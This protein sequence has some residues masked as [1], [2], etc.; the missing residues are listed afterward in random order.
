MKNNG[1]QSLVEMLVAVTVVVIVVLGLVLA[2]TVSLRNAR[3]SKDQAL[4]S[5]YAQEWIEEARVLKET[6]PNVF[7]A[8]TSLCNRSPTA[9]G[10]IFTRS[11]VCTL[12]TVPGDSTKKIMRVVVSVQWTDA[13]GTHK[14]ELT[15]DLTNWK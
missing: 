12:S 6:Q 10:G 4:A 15:T 9:V 14:S 13:K 7:F 3:F 5:K 8:D 1:G 2:T 11:R